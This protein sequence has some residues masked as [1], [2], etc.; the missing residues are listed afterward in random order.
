MVA[1]AVVSTWL[2]PVVLAP[3][4][5][6]F[7]ALPPGQARSDVIELGERA[8]VDDRRGLRGRR[9][10]PL[11]GAERLRERVG[12]TKRV[13]L[14]DTLLDELQPPR[15]SVRGRPRA[16]P[17]SSNADIPRGM[18]WVAIVAPFGL[19]FAS[20]LAAGSP[21]APAPSPARR[22]RCPRYA[23]A[24]SVTV[25]ALTIASNQLSRDVEA[26][27]D[28]YALELTGDPRGLID[29]Q[30]RLAETNLSDPDPPDWSQLLF[31]THPTTV[32]RIGAAR[33]YER[34]GETP[35]AE[36]RCAALGRERVGCAPQPLVEA[37]PADCQPSVS[38]AR[39]LESQMR[40]ISPGRAGSIAARTSCRRSARAISPS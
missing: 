18:L 20:L 25:F 11:D 28:D 9:E 19:L 39:S 4:F 1:F 23:L 36:P 27:A 6:R 37:R 26:A 24:L 15:A 30:T 17:T 31:G 33:A 40:W 38:R 2:A 7:E 21:R 5:N 22:R 13:V 12:P 10:P 14:Y 34:V 32:E 35:L 16:R 3:L 29:L 8:G